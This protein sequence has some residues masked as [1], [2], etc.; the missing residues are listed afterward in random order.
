MFDRLPFAA[1]RPPACGL[2]LA[3]IGLGLFAW[4]HAAAALP[5]YYGSICGH[6]PTDLHCAGCYVAAAIIA[7]GLI[8]ARS[9][10]DWRRLTRLACSLT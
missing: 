3:S 10:A 2:A 1:P 5:F 8:A 4:L 9:S 6:R 7:T